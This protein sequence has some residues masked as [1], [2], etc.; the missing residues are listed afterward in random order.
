MCMI[1]HA[2]ICVMI[3]RALTRPFSLFTERGLRGKPPGL[4]PG[5]S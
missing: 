4:D 2:E 1:H 5:H 3:K